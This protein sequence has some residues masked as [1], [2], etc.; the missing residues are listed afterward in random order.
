[1]HVHA[2]VRTRIYVRMCVCNGCMYARESIYVHVDYTIYIIHTV[3]TCR[4]K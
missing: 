1:M 3:C 4:F 2:H